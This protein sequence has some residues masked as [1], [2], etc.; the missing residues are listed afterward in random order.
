[1]GEVQARAVQI[2]PAG[3]YAREIKEIVD[4]PQQPVRVFFTIV[5]L[6]RSSPVICLSSSNRSA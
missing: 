6:S 4:Q 1:M 5:R 2:D 3:L